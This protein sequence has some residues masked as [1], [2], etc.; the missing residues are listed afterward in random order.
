MSHFGADL[1]VAAGI[2]L[3]DL[4]TV[5]RGIATGA[6]DYFIVD[7]ATIDKYA[8]PR[9]Y[10]KPILPSPRYVRDPVIEGSPDGT[11]K[12]E[13]FGYLLDCTATPDEV[14]RKHPG[15]WSYFEEGVAQ[16]LPERHLCSQ[17]DEWYFQEKREPAPFIVSYMGRSRDQRACPIRFFVNF[18]SAIVTN[19]F[20]NLYPTVEL[21]EILGDDRSRMLEFGEALNA[22]P[23]EAMLHAG[24]AYGGGLH[25]IEPKELR[26][27]PLSIVPSWL[28]EGL[29]RRL[30]LF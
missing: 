15:L 25:K 17:R 23:A 18:S 24:R 20:L 16:G 29:K 10:L 19:V 26:E 6:N 8:I 4:F 28:E 13:R 9:L 27:V 1:S 12:V 7:Q 11:P 21:S 22:I 2:R 5:R 3:K 30:L 14:K